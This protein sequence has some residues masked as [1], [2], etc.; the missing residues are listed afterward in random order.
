MKRTLAILFVMSMIFMVGSS[1]FA[2][3]AT[4]AE[5]NAQLK[6]QLANSTLMSYA[7]ETEL[8]IDLPT[9]DVDWFVTSATFEDST[10]TLANS[11][12]IYPRNVTITVADPNTADP[13]FVTVDAFTITV[14]GVTQKAV[15]QTETFTFSDW[16]NGSVMTGDHAYLNLSS[17]V[18]SDCNGLGGDETITV[19][20]GTKMALTNPLKYTSDVLNVSEISAS[21]EH[22]TATAN[23]TYDTVDLSGTAPNGTK[24]YVIYYRTR[25]D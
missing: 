20:F 10:L 17:V 14:T 6:T 8:L 24:D 23:A 2:A 18:I 22:I 1:V 9:A 12:N 15:S 5:A 13:N 4:L 16:T 25:N 11:Y 19:G 3:Q 21:A 7:Y